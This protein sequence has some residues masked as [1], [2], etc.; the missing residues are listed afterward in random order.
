MA[1]AAARRGNLRASHADRE[2]VIDVLKTAFVQGRLTKDEF[3]L[4]LGQTLASRTYAELAALTADIP[5]GLAGSPPLR[6]PPQARAPVN[7][8]GIWAA[9]L[10]IALGLLVG[11][12]FFNPLGLAVAVIAVF[13][14]GPVAGTLMQDS[15]RDKHSRGQPPPGPHS[16]A[17]EG[18]RD[19]RAALRRDYGASAVAPGRP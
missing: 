6:R 8:A 7:K 11:M 16:P 10:I 14:A 4:R 18:K 12:S 2:Q 13:G 19:G 3:D 1:A 9:G 17:L 5:S 15:W